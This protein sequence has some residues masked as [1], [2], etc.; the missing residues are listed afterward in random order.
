LAHPPPSLFSPVSFFGHGSPWLR[1]PGDYGKPL[2]LPFS[3]YSLIGLPGPSPTIEVL[4]F[5]P[6]AVRIPSPTKMDWYQSSSRPIWPSA[7]PPTGWVDPSS[8]TQRENSRVVLF[9]G[10]KRVPSLRPLWSCPEVF[11][12][13][14]FQPYPSFC[15]P[16]PRTRRAFFL[17]LFLLPFGFERDSP[18]PR[19]QPPLVFP[20]DEYS[21][22]SQSPF[23]LCHDIPV[24]LHFIPVSTLSFFARQL[25]TSFPFSFFLLDWVLSRSF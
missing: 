17:F 16:L 10:L 11:W 3:H 23:P 18:I 21:N 6:S 1:S 13:L 7:I 9:F 22:T 12:R 8:P 19:G 2:C 5:M 15:F 14:D 24:F 25:W 20:E 4:F